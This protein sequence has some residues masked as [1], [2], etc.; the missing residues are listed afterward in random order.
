MKAIGYEKYG[1]GFDPQAVRD[2]GGLGLVSMRERAGRIGGQLAIHSVPGEGT[3]I[4]VQIA[5]G[6]DE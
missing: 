4:T 5:G 1:K 6:M 2:R 3:K